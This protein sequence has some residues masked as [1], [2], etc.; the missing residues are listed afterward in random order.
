MKKKIL[1][2]S[3][4]IIALISIFASIQYFHSTQKKNITTKKETTDLKLTKEQEKFYNQEDVQE[5][6]SMGNRGIEEYN[7]THKTKINLV[8]RKKYI[9]YIK[10]GKKL[11]CMEG[12]NSDAGSNIKIFETEQDAEDAGYT[13]DTS[14]K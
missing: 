10:N 14:L 11:Y 1:L 4:S 3:I 13:L 12:Q 6:L 5:A 9:G 2:V 7:A 8:E